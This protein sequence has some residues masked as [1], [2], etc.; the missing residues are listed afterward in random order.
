MT[1]QTTAAAPAADDKA[2]AA[3]AKAKAKAEAKAKK[4][5]ERADK[6]A[7]KDKE[8]A[9]KKAAK[10]AE[11]AA[12]KQPEQNGIRRPKA[13]TITGK[14]WA[15]FDELSQKAGA[16]ATIGDSLKAAAGTAEATVRTQ[17]ARWR[18]FHGISGRTE[19]PAASA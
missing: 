7:A 18:K 17:Y 1:E 12:A 6:K 16:P 14:V 9:D 8:K 10:E 2:A 11:K 19:K 4:D 3:E 13:D 15:V 5:Q